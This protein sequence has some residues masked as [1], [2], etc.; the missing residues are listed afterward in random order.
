[1]TLILGNYSTLYK[2]AMTWWDH[3]TRSVWSQPWGTAIAG[4]LEGVALTPSS[5]SPWSTWLAEHPETTLVAD[6]LDGAAIAAATS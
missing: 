4:L 2:R 6:D 1:M 5:V 3:N